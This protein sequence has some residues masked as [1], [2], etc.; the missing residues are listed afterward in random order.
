LLERTE[1]CRRL[2]LDERGERLT[3]RQFARLIEEL[4]LG[5]VRRAAFLVGGSDGHSEEVRAKADRVL[6]LSS[7]TL[8]HE[9]ALVVLLEQLYRGY[10]ILRGLPYH[11]D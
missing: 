10:A 1:G 5:G 11:R 4:E 7:L 3:S 6:S 2:V 8:Q 9:L